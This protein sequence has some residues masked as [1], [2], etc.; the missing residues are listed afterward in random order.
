MP[1]P[2]LAV[3]IST[4]LLLGGARTISDWGPTNPQSFKNGDVIAVGRLK[5]QNSDLVEPDPEDMIGHGWFTATFHVAHTESGRLPAKVVRV[6]YFG[7]TFLREDIKFRFHLRP[8]GSG[9]YFICKRSDASG[10]R[11]D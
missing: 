6:R 1:G 9:D 4:L 11:C 5:K 7:H 8:S 10:Y 3:L 2:P